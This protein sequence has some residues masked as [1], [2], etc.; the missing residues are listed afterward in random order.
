[1][2]HRIHIWKLLT[3]LVALTFFAACQ[4]NPKPNLQKAEIK[5]QV[6]TAAVIRGNITDTLTI[7][8]VLALRQEAWLSSQFDGRLTEFSLLKGASVVKGQRTG[9]IIPARREALL[10]ASKNISDELKPLLEEQEKEIPL[11]SPVTGIVLN[12]L[13]HTGDVVA[14]GEH[15]AHIAD[16]K[17][18]DVQGEVPLQYLESVQHAKVL[19]IQ[20][21][22]FTHPVFSLPIEAFAGSV[23][24]NQSL[25]IRL[26]LDNPTLKFRPGMR[27]KISFPTQEHKQALLVTRTALLEEEGQYS[28]FLIKNGK[29]IK[30]AVKVG[31]IQA[32]I[33]EIISGVDENQ[34]IAIDKVY[35][36][37]DN[38]EITTK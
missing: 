28:V 5:I 23:S 25:L 8:G 9:V 32:D 7:F 1:M 22:N 24:E 30:K 3:L 16:L 15:I 21:T 35:S 33:V 27:V 31:I 11:Y 38:L 26:K 4:P 18:L 13:M 34:I 29:T 36:L 6:K 2:N 12:V 37:K 10:Q 14:K 17:T 19:N 20:F